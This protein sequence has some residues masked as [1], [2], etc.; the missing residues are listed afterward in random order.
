M[1]IADVMSW[2]MQYGITSGLA[3][4]IYKAYGDNAIPILENNPYRLS[5]DIKGVGFKKADEVAKKLG[6]PSDSEYRIQS[7]LNAVLEDAAVRG[8]TY[9]EQPELVSIAS[10]QDFLNLPEETVEPVIDSFGF[11]GIAMNTDG[12]ISL[13]KYF[14]AEKKIAERLKAIKENG[15]KK[16]SY[17]P[18]YCRIEKTTGISYSGQQR[19]AIKEAIQNPVFIMTGGPGTG[20]TTTTNAIINECEHLKL[21]ILLAAPTGRAAKRITESTG[22]EAKTIHRLIEYKQGEF[23]RNESNP[24]PADVV[25]IDEASMIDT[26]LMK[27]F[28]KAVSDKTKLIIIGDTDQLPSVGAGCVLRDMIYSGQFKTVRLT[29]IY[30]QA[31]NSKIITNAHLINNG[32]MPAADNADNGENKNDFWFF[33]VEDR[34]KISDLIVDL[35][36]NRIPRKFGFCPADVQVLSPMRRDFDPI[37][38]T[39]LNE[40]LQQAINPE[41]QKAATRSKTEFRIGDRVMQTKNNYDKNVINGDIGEVLEKFNRDLEE[42]NAVM[43]VLFDGIAVRYK[44]ED[45][46]ELELAYACTIHKSQGSEYPA[47]MIPIH[48]SHFIMLKRNLIYTGI[49]RAKKQCILIGNK[50]ALAMAV[51]TEDTEKRQTQLQQ[52][53][54][55]TAHEESG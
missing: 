1:A 21:S 53:I 27:D 32:Y 35:V 49:T 10:S 3:V 55:E 52:R 19:E 8:N 13:L 15:K 17:N 24:L 20:K 18:D 7:G 39:I 9:M 36:Q 48:T 41:G 51:N 31:R 34:D 50:K 43:S 37:G 26:I 25:I 6:L 22:K 5:D 30:R 11:L 54:I 12:K 46:T 42:D 2:L 44:Q 29:E 38:S 33:T 47:V 45:L 4:K 40:K 23:T 14:Y 28:L 16:E